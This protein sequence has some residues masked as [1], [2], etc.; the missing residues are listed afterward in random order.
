MQAASAAEAVFGS[1]V[2][3][4]AVG[5]MLLAAVVVFVV[6]MSLELVI[7]FLPTDSMPHDK[8]QPRVTEP[9]RDLSEANMI[10]TGN[11]L[12]SW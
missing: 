2:Q 6:V 3:G 4:V 10:C 5:V 11:C 1:V 8:S 7:A 9:K 12:K